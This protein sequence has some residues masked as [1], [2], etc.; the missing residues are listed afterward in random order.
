MNRRKFLGI[1]SGMFVAFA[2][3]LCR[4]AKKSV[5]G[6]FTRADRG[7]KYPGTIKMPE[8]INGIGKWSG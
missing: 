6:K 5:P 1:I 7:K 8:D 2:G 4:L 3:G